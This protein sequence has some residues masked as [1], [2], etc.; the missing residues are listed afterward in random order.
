MENAEASVQAGDR[1]CDVLSQ[2]MHRP[3]GMMLVVRGYSAPPSLRS[4]NRK[5]TLS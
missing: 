5:L 2:G 1:L 4:D 3:T